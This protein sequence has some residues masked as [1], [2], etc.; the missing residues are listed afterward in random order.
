ML[1]SAEGE[2]MS[3][4]TAQLFAEAW[5]QYK[6]YAEEAHR[7]YASKGADLIRQ[8]ALAG[9]AVVW[10]FRETAGNGAITLAAQLRWAAILFVLTLAID[11]VHYLCSSVALAWVLDDLENDE[12]KALSR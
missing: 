11:L 5:K 9:V 8:T 7:S 4:N 1:P 10:V 3:E 2:I 6:E 12:Q